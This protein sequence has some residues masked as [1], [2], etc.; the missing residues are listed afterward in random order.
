[1]SLLN[2]N[3]LQHPHWT[4]ELANRKDP[5]EAYDGPL[6]SDDEKGQTR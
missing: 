4:M 5:V 1:M 2:V 6:F 3:S